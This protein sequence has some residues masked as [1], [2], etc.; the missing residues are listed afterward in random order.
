MKKLKSI[1]LSI[2]ARFI[3]YI[4][5]RFTPDYYEIK[6]ENKELKQD[7][8]Y[9]IKKENRL[10][11]MMTKMKWNVKID[12]DNILLFG[13]SLPEDCEVKEITSYFNKN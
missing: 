1:L 5:K 11:G 9:L 2:K 8:Y 7:L 13:S 3:D 10:E 4:I 12:I 6:A